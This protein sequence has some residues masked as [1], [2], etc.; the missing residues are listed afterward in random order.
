[1][2]LHR[3]LPI[4]LCVSYGTLNAELVLAPLFQD[5]AVIQRDKSVPVWGRGT[6]GKTVRV[7]FAGQNKSGQVDKA[8]RWAV[9]L[10]AIPGNAKP[11][12]MTIREG[13]ERREIRDLLVGEVWLASGQSN[14]EWPIAK[15]RSEDQE[16]AKTRD[17]PLL[18]LFQVQHGLSHSRKETLKGTWRNA[19]AD[20]LADYSAVAYFFGRNLVEKLD[21]PVGV[22]QSAWGGS[23]IEP[24]WAEEGLDGL[25]ELAEVAIQ[26]LAKSPG[27]SAYDE[28]YRKFISEV[29]AWTL[30]ATEALDRGEHPLNMPKEPG[31]LKLGHNGETGTYQAMIH[32]LVPYALR[33]F[34]WYQGESNNGEGMAYTSKMEALIRGW[35]HQFGAADAPFLYVQLAPYR[36][37]QKK[38]DDLPRIWMAQ[39]AALRIPNTGMVVTNDIGNPKDI[40]PVNKSEVGR[41]L[42]VL[43]LAD[44]YGIPDLVKSG[45]LFHKY[46]VT[47]NELVI[48]FTGTGTG[49]ATRGGGTPDHFEIA[50]AD[51]VYHPAK[52]EIAIDGKS[53]RLS[54]DKVPLPQHARFAWNDTAEPNLMNKEALPAA[55]FA[56]DAAQLSP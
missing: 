20:N 34:L 49:L 1:M 13:E 39:Q 27:F 45:P 19:R 40:H 24:W 53:L 4:L 43:A 50:G 44:T 47:G 51:G 41:R 17:I 14:M 33:G 16:I 23:R 42:A 31:L 2:S 35:R 30:R 29:D 56:T 54:S 7:D 55:A 22:I 5:G 52:A 15:S 46:Q 25:P 21:V 26:R 32:P 9:M 10:D 37:P 3:C 18:R 28:A 12:S 48:H 36:Y 11:Q 38:P 6:P 8:G